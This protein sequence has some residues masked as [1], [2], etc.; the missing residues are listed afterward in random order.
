MMAANAALH[1][2]RPNV[3]LLYLLQNNPLGA[4]ELEPLIN[5][6]RANANLLEARD[7]STALRYLNPSA[8]APPSAVLVA[9]ATITE[10]TQA[11]L[12]DALVEYARA[13]GRVVFGVRFGSHF[14]YFEV[15]PLFRRFGMLWDRGRLYRSTFALNPNGIPEPLS[16]DPLCPA[17]TMR[18]Q[19]I[20]DVPP[21]A[22][23]Y[24][25]TSAPAE[26]Y[27][28][29]IERNDMPVKEVPAAFAPIAQGYIGYVGDV[30]GEQG[31]TR[32]LLEMCGVKVAHSDLGSS[33]ASSDAHVLPDDHVVS[34]SDTIP[35]KFIPCAQS[36]ASSTRENVT[37]QEEQ[38]QKTPAIAPK[39]P[40]ILILYLSNDLPLHLT[41]GQL[42]SG[43]E[44][45]ATVH[46]AKDQATALQ[47]L[48]SPTLPDA[49]LVADA[50][51][52][53]PEHAALLPRLIEYARS[54]GKVILGVRFSYLLNPG[55]A[56]MFFGL[57]G[58]PWS[59]GTNGAGVFALN[60]NQTP[61]PL[62]PQALFPAF[63]GSAYTLQT[64]SPRD[65]V[66]GRV[67]LRDPPT[68]NGRAAFGI[69]LQEG[70]ALWTAIGE[71]F[72]GYVGEG[73]AEQ[74]Y[75]RITLEMLG[76][77]IAPGDLGPRN[78]LDNV[79]FHPGGRVEQ[80]E[81]PEPEI[82][83]P[84]PLRPREIEAVLRAQRRAGV[85][86]EKR[87]KA[88]GFK[89]EGNERFRRG[90]FLAAAEF[91]RGAALTYGPRPVYMSNLAVALLKLELYDVAESAA[92]RALYHDPK[93]VKARFRRA[94]ARRHTKRYYAAK[95]DVQKLLR[96]DP[97]NEAALVELTTIEELK[98]KGDEL[99]SPRD[100]EETPEDEDHYAV[101]VEETSDSE[102][103]DHVG[104]GEPCWDYNHDGCP[105][106]NSCPKSHGPGPESVR[107]EL[108]RNVC[109]RWLLL[110][111]CSKGD[112]CAYAHDDTFLPKS[113][114]WA[115]KKRLDRIRNEADQMARMARKEYPVDLL[116]REL[117]PKPS[118]F[119]SW[120]LVPFGMTTEERKE[121]ERTGVHT[122]GDSYLAAERQF[123]RI[124]P[125]KADA[126][127]TL[128]MLRALN[129]NT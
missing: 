56:A 65:V 128:E 49:I 125:S 99:C 29:A 38:V 80:V 16:A 55:S 22:A 107:D 100:F 5:G 52:A 109:L 121:R 45:N 90:D 70:P 115:D 43:L 110:S 83:L 101:E 78:V 98:K 19:L 8:A 44:K 26:N 2:E 28:G 123:Y 111:A 58:V 6:I 54:G 60:P 102:D 27:P 41:H 57:W 24:V 61:A 14:P 4:T 7:S 17:Y 119:E 21:E 89:D 35:D 48:S 120:A 46:K 82:P 106:G 62:S 74:A 9:D 13:G 88:E 39:R 87:M 47:H 72:L 124:D 95:T 127:D 86:Q 79:T 97:A 84:Y 71:G 91:Y 129:H 126:F 59:L 32:L 69:N 94:L 33:T 104:N 11:A 103:Y 93:N 85:Q 64:T 77:K 12:V 105:R 116:M 81:V 25:T 76:V 31:S 34:K 42:L 117:I 53:E 114:W 40:T 1:P 3:L 37:A 118:Q 66:Y 68:H 67:E 73:D 20:T 15:A 10:P 63:G 113:G 23:V 18:A 92:T 122:E 112:A 108:G 75:V 50:S 51:V 30:N 96:V 36:F